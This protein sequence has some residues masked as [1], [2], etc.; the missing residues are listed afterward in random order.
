MHSENWRRI[1][2]TLLIIL[3]FEIKLYASGGFTLHISKDGKH[4]DEL[5]WISSDSKINYT[6]KDSKGLGAF[7]MKYRVEDKIN[8][9]HGSETETK[10]ITQDEQ[11]VHLI[12]IDEQET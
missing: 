1:F 6:R 8:T 10:I 3:A 9:V 11:N 7:N 5:N 2:I 12:G 4:L